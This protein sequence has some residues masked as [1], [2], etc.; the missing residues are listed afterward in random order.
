MTQYFEIRNAPA[1]DGEVIAL[2]KK[3]SPSYH[4]EILG[5]EAWMSACINKDLI[6][7]TTEEE[8]S[9][10]DVICDIPHILSDGVHHFLGELT[11]VYN[12]DSHRPIVSSRS[13]NKTFK[14]RVYALIVDLDS[15]DQ[16]NKFVAK[17]GEWEVS[18]EEEVIMAEEYKD[19]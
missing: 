9:V 5:D 15:P 7:E 12:P 16:I 6:R 13:E 17:D 11:L 14:T 1:P 4:L 10:M 18:D 8:F 2:W 3:E 19:D